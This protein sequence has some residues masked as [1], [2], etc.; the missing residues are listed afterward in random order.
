MC[1]CIYLF[2][3]AII[4]FYFIICL[5]S[6]FTKPFKT[7]QKSEPRGFFPQFGSWMHLVSPFQPGTFWDAL[8]QPSG[9]PNP[10]MNA[11][12]LLF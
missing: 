6:S 4:T 1:L 7:H 2:I 3:Y 10:A 11:L 12:L 5:L 8:T 9:I